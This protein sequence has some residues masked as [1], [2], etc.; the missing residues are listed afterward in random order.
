MANKT[1][2]YELTFTFKSEGNR[3]QPFVAKSTGTTVQR[4]FSKLAKDIQ[5]GKW[6]SLDEANVV[7][8]SHEE[9]DIRPS[10]LM[11]VE[12]KCLNP[13]KH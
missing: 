12:A 4:A 8:D 11:L 10:D 7:P 5:S 2:T 3:V 1:F 9:E 13:I 6:E